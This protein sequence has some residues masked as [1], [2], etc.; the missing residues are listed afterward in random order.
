MKN[1][2]VEQIILFLTIIQID[3]ATY[4]EPIKTCPGVIDVISGGA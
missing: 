4:D 3:V 2:T 1:C